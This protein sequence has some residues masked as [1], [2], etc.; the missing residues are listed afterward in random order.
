MTAVQISSIELLMSTFNAVLE[1]VELVRF[2]YNHQRFA[3]VILPQ[4]YN[5]ASRYLQT[6]GDVLCKPYFF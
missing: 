1:D 2:R 5:V 4:N 3:L 6:A